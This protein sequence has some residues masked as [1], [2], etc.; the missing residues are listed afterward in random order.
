M[1]AKLVK[2]GSISWDTKFLDIYPELK[3]GALEVYSE[4]TLEDLLA[5]RAGILPYTS[6]L[7]E[8]PELSASQDKEVGFIRYLLSQ[9][10]SAGKSASGK[11]EFLY[12]CRF[13][14]GCCHAGEGHRLTL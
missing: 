5:C 6:G 7:E 14:L 8:Y 1:A 12:Q 11:F 4:I 3:A 10:P 2:E 9:P 13:Y